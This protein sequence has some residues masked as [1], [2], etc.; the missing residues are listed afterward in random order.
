MKNF[1]S[2]TQSQNF[3]RA[4]YQ[5]W[6]DIYKTVPTWSFEHL[7]RRYYELLYHLDLKGKSILEVGAGD[8]FLSH[9]LA[10]LKGVKDVVSLD[11]YEGHG[12]DDKHTK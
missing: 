12:S 3:K 10:L 2:N 11:E 5:A 7:S 4:Y 6:Q 8:G 1:S 9:Y